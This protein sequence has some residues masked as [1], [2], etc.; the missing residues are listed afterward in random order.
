[1]SF[2]SRSLVA[3][4]AVL[5]CS[6]AS[7]VDLVANGDFELGASNWNLIPTTGITVISAY[8]ACCSI[9]GT[10]AGGQNAAFFG[11]D[12][13]TG[14]Q[15]WQDMTT[16]IG[17]QYTLTFQYGAISANSLQSLKAEVL[18]GTSVL[19]FLDVS[20]TGTSNLAA[21]L[22][23]PYSLSFVASSITTRLLFSDTSSITNSVD[24]VLD[25]ISVTAVPE[26]GTYAMLLAGLAAVGFV[27][28]RRKL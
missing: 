21:I 15:I 3:A 24:G 9:T 2:V 16:T 18:D 13:L 28:R 8:S 7:A 25:N 26:P 20:A 22:S 11:W 17:Q 5:A 27:A 4:A 14:G 12:N 19:G 23:A 6:G 1:M 10:Y